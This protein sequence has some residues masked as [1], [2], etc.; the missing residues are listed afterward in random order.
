MPDGTSALRVSRPTAPESPGGRGGLEM[1]DV[2]LLLDGMPFRNEQ[3]V[4][5]HTARTTI[6]VIDV[7]TGLRQEGVLEL[8]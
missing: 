2:I 8:P 1:G 3:D 7:K 6:C 4:M 5:N